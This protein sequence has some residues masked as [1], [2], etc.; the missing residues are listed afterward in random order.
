MGFSFAACALLEATEIYWACASASVLPKPCCK[1]HHC[2]W[3]CGTG[4]TSL[5]KESVGLSINCHDG[6]PNTRQHC[7]ILPR[8]LLECS[9]VLSLMQSRKTS[10]A[11]LGDHHGSGFSSLRGLL[12]S[13]LVYLWRSSSRDFLIGSRNLGC[14]TVKRLNSPSLGAKV[15]IIKRTGNDYHADFDRFKV[16]TR[17]GQVVSS[18]TR[19]VRAFSIRRHGTWLYSPGS[20]RHS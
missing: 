4:E 3:C 7:S 14:L 12:R 11:L 15:S 20:I 9:P 19:S 17:K 2:T 18:P 16:S 1:P 13:E 8:S 5:V 10:K 6:Y